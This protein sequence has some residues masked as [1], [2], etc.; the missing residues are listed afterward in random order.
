MFAIRCHRIT[1]TCEVEYDKEGAVKLLEEAGWKEGKDG[2]REKD[3]VKAE[4]NL[5]FNTGDSVRQAI[6]EDV[7][8]QLGELGIKVTTEGV[9]WDVAYDKAQS[10]PLVW[11]WGDAHCDG[12][13]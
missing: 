3:G 6:A 12:I 5:M 4:L 7:A 9:G 11:G 8:N 2:I 13:I 10:E 1:K